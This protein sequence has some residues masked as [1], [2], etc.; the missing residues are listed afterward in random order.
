MIDAVAFQTRARTIDHLGREQIAD[1]PTAISE[2]WKNSYD[3]YA[4]EVGLHIYDGPVT[5][6]ALVDDGHGM[7]RQEF[8]EKWLVV[9]T[10]SKANGTQTVEEDRNG[11]PTRTK[12]GQKG[13]GRLSAAALGPLLL[14]VS[15]RSGCSFVGALIDWRIFENPF[16]YLHDIEIPVVEFNQKEDIFVHLPSMFETLMGNISGNKTNSARDMRVVDAWDRFDDVNTQEGRKSVR[17]TIEDVI[18]N[19][20]FFEK[21]FEQWPVW[22]EDSSHGTALLIGDVN[23]DLEVHL[24]SKVEVADE[25]TAKQATDRLFQTLSNFTDPFI[26]EHETTSDFASNEFKYSVTAWEGTLRRPIIS[27][28]RSFSYQNLEELEHV[29]DGSVDVLG[30]FRGRIKAFGRWLDGEI[31]LLPK[32]AVPTRSDALVGPFQLRLGTFEQTPTNSSHPP[33]IH[34]KLAEQAAKYAGFMVYRNGL[35]VMPYGREDNDFFEIEKRRNLH[36][37]REFWSYRRLFGRVALTR[38][39]NPNLKDKAG[40]E[41]IIDNKAAKV[42]RDIVEN[43]LM[44]TAR[45]YFGS[46]SSVRKELL[47]EV[48]ASRE[49]ERAEEAQKKL[50]ARRK[51]EFRKNL[52]EFL[53]KMSILCA[54]L[55][56]IAESARAE[57]LPDEETELLKIRERIG[58]LKIKRSE[59]SL[60]QAPSNLGTLEEDY[61][62]FRSSYTR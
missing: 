26:R 29:V 25:Q 32:T 55:E 41:G 50:R 62:V 61:H 59:L 37:G 21:H 19:T 30:V 33:E 49:K 13:I 53:P 12:Q 20:A 9:G 17:K 40:R 14:L 38:E 47:P 24:T 5:I 1:C 2:L 10:E 44:T 58:E 16:L 23:F 60:G 45:R 11:L 27:Q 6:A 34:A 43:I 39:N 3:A 52:K 31:T 57:S 4:R 51:R 48:I 42:F 56:T 54:E 7:S 35:R 46:D 18:I 15:K 22:S 8:V 36:A 28:D